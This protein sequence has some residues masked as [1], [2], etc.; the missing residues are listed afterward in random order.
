MVTALMTDIQLKKLS[1]IKRLIK[2][3]KRKFTPRPD[4]DY[5][6]DL[7]EIGITEEVAW[8]EILTLSSI[9]YWQDGKPFYYKKKNEDALIFKKYINDNLVYIKLDIDNEHNEN[10]TVCL[11]FH[12]DHR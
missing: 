12:I 9:N 11:S 8:K 10:M 2:Q 3:G 7:L 1:S 6:A 4:R 5:I